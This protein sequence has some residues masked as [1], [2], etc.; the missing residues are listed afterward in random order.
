M[1]FLHLKSNERDNTCNDERHH[2]NST[3]IFAVHSSYWFTNRS[4]GSS[5]FGCGDL[6]NRSNIETMNIAPRISLQSGCT[7]RVSKVHVASV[8][9]VGSRDFIATIFP[10]WSVTYNS[11]IQCGS[12]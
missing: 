5:V 2:S 4:I 1:Q 12:V 3:R 6:H 7:L 8:T 11:V 9:P 10:S